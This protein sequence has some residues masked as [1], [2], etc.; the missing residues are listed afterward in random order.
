[1]VTATGMGA[2]SNLPVPVFDK[3]VVVQALTN[4]PENRERSPGSSHHLGK[5]TAIELMIFGAF[6]VT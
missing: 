4:N 6:G 3:I 5:G 1:M 2:S